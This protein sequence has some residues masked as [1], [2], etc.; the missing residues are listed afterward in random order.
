MMK[1]Q[2]GH[3]VSG[4][5]GG[6][7]RRAP[8]LTSYALTL[9]FI[10]FVSLLYFKDFS[11]TL[12]QPF[13]HHPPQRHRRPHIG[14][15]RQR[16]RPP[17]QP[18]VAAAGEGGAGFVEKAAPERPAFAVGA[19]AAGCD[20]SKGEW[21][22]D[23]AARPLYSEEECPYIQPQLTCKE[24]GRPDT[25]YRHWRWQPRGCDLPRYGVS[26]KIHYRRQRI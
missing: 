5:G 16:P 2:H 11:S 10:T 17:L 22:Y 12:H 25:A 1:A 19:A 18:H 24:H 20:I 26:S 7:G 13:L 21:V 15:H 3:G 14:P 4:G 9:A 6:H 8:F 23:E